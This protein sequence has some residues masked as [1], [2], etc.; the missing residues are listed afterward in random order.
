MRKKLSLED[1]FWSKVDK[2]G[3]DDCW[4][5]KGATKKSGPRRYASFQGRSASRFAYQFTYGAYPHPSLDV[6]HRCDNTNCVNPAHLFL[7]T[8]Q[9]NMQDAK[10]KG[11]TAHNT[12]KLNAD[13]ARDIHR[14]YSP[15]IVSIY[16]LAAVFGV[17]ANTVSRVLNGVIWRSVWEEFNA[18]TPTAP[19]AVAA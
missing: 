6:C 17:N 7:G 19:A 3:D 12:R 8:R 11:R 14:R 5:W 10:A 2:R 9:Q 4:E 16:D 1:R 15:G 13:Q 18:P